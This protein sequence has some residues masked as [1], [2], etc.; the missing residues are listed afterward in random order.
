ML[1]TTKNGWAGLAEFVKYFNSEYEDEIYIRPVSFLG[2]IKFLFS[3]K[4]FDY[5]SKRVE[6]KT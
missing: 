2:A 6:R 5:D 3:K 4:V 1:V